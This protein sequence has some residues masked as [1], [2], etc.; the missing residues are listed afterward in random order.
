MPCLHLPTGT[1]VINIGE[2]AKALVDPSYGGDRSG[3]ETFDY[4]HRVGDHVPLEGDSDD[5]RSLIDK[6]REK[7]MDSV[8]D[9]TKGSFISDTKFNKETEISKR[10]DTKKSSLTSRS[11]DKNKFSSSRR[12]DESSRKKDDGKPFFSDIGK[13]D[14]KKTK[15]EEM[16]MEATLKE[17]AYLRS[18]Q[19]GSSTNDNPNSKPKVKEMYLIS[20]VKMLFQRKKKNISSK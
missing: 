12:S 18:I 4:S 9:S 20:Q 11:T 10:K 6:Q 15:P 1:I 7:E 13:S 19:T 16:D 2:G 17:L 5:L 8:N 3:V 14:K